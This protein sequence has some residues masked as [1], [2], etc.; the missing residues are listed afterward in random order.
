MK[1]VKLIFL[2][3]L[4]IAAVAGCATI[5][6]YSATDKPQDGICVF[7]TK[8]YLLV[9]SAKTYVISLPDYERVYYIKPRSIL[10]KHKFSIEIKEGQAKTV[11][12]NEDTTA[13]TE[14][15][16][17]A[18]KVVGATSGELKGEMDTKE[19]VAGDGGDFQIEG[20]FGLNPGLYQLNDKG[21]ITPVVVK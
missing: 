19:P 21:S 7:P 13:V 8:I 5:K 11:N 18:L 3:V 15:M 9:D 6:T 14:L 10:S 2:G 17:E 4:I 1:K 16:I 12:S 20:T